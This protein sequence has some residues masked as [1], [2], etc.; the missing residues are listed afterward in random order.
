MIIESKHHSRGLSRGTLDIWR[1][2]YFHP[3]A[4]YRERGDFALRLVRHRD[5]IQRG[6]TAYKLAFPRTSSSKKESFA[7]FARS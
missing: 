6:D 5:R 7:S 3:G 2:I 1:S 4:V